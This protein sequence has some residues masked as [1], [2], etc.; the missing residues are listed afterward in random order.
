MQFHNFAEMLLGSK[1]KVKLLRHLLAEGGV[2]SER[3]V[4][5]ILGVSHS[6]VNKIVEEFYEL[7]L[8]KPARAGNVKIWGLNEGS[9]ANE[10][11]RRN[12]GDAIKIS[13]MEHLKG[14]IIDCLGS[15]KTIKKLVI[16]GSVAEGKE[17]P[18][19]DIDLF[20]LIESEKGK[21][22]VLQAVAG[23]D[24]KCLHRYGN[25]LSAHIFTPADVKNSENTELLKNVD[26]G[27]VVKL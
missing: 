12:L 19:S 17:L 18:N 22:D 13:P 9:F 5:K 3:E 1:V 16:F 15:L 8:I 6:A 14:A 27:I 2:S 23:L 4:A 7:N 20:I 26:K 25:K 11:L 24:E 10:F 21:K